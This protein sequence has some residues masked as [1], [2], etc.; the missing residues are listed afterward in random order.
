MWLKKKSSTITYKIIVLFIFPS[1]LFSYCPINIFHFKLNHLNMCLL[2]FYRKLPHCIIMFF[3]VR[4]KYKCQ[5]TTS[6]YIVHVDFRRIQRLWSFQV[7]WIILII[8][9]IFPH[10]K[11]H[12]IS[13]SYESKF[14]SSQFGLTLCQ[15]LRELKHPMTR[16]RIYTNPNQKNPLT[17]SQ[18]WMCHPTRY[19]TPDSSLT[20]IPPPPPAAT[21]PPQ[22][23]KLQRNE[24]PSESTNRKIWP[25][26]TA[27]SPHWLRK[28][29]RRVGWRRRRRGCRPVG[30]LKI[31]L[32]LLAQQLER[33]IRL[34]TF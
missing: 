4:K 11:R 6:S 3:W 34:L 32:G 14:K 19:L 9:I 16:I 1:F 27:R 28:P 18:L 7:K 31:G 21:P 8:H 17:Y 26:R 29:R 30:K 5:Y 24:G 13:K 23:I 15:P 2:V 22:M 25:R 10:N 12:G 20:P 33:W